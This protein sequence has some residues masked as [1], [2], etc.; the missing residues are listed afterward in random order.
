MV[1]LPFVEQAN[2]V[3]YDWSG[4]EYD[5]VSAGVTLGAAGPG[6]DLPAYSCDGVND[7]AGNISSGGLLTDM[8]AVMVSA[9]GKFTFSGWVQVSGAGVWGDANNR[10]IFFVQSMGGGSNLIDIIKTTVL[11]QISARV[12]LAGTSKTVTVSGYSNTNYFHVAIIY[13]KEAETFKFFIDGVQQGATQDLTGEAWDAT[14]VSRV[15][16]GHQV[17]AVIWDGLF[18]R[19]R[20]ILDVA[21]ADD[22]ITS[23]ANIAP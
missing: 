7:Q 11:N 14:S 12:I 16:F 4:N 5:A 3:A 19:H 18:A 21:L 2:S 22:Q 9:T 15:D 20:L 10:S 17:F 13:D 8:Q 1:L 23:L 6:D